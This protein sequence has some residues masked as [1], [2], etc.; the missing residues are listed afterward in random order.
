MGEL[1]KVYKNFEEWKEKA[2]FTHATDLSK[3]DLFDFIIKA[4]WEACATSKD[5]EYCN[6]FY[7]IGRALKKIKT[8]VY[9]AT[10]EGHHPVT[11]EDTIDDFFFYKIPYTQYLI[12]KEC[13]A[14]IER[15]QDENINS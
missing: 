6:K 7:S 2:T 15:S 12:L 3:P 13:I 8:V 4:T 5:H 9:A 14:I 1:G 11:T 10:A